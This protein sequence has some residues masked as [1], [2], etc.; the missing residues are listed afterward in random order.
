MYNIRI[1]RPEQFAGNALQAFLEEEKVA[2]LAQ[3]AHALA[4]PAPITV[5]RKLKDLSCLSSY[6][7]AGKYYTLPKI[8]QWNDQGLWSWKGIRFSKHRTLK[9]TIEAWVVGSEAGYFEPELQKGL[10]VQVRVS[11]G[12]LLQEGRIGREKVSGLYLYGSPEAAARLRQ[13]LARR[14]RE[15]LE[16]PG[17][18]VLQHEIKAAILLF[19]SLLDEK[20]RRLYAGI[21]S[22]K[23]GRGGDQ[24]IAQWL[25]V[26]PRTVAKGREELLRRDMEIERTRRAGGGRPPLEKKRPKS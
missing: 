3:L 11:L 6:S 14:S 23:L 25:G 5:R 21:E 19:F 13:T 8:A 22:L 9:R 20:Q 1:M 2:T 17:P 24:T 4:G 26:H 10:K 7:H 16:L 12:N 15:G 18:Q